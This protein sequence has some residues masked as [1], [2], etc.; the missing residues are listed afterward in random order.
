MIDPCRITG[1]EL[2]S[3]EVAKRKRA[4]GRGGWRP[5]AGR[6]AVLDDPVSVTLDLEGSQIARLREIAERE[7]V[8][9][10]SLVRKAVSGFLA[11]KRK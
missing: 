2:L 7:E 8:S 5:G 6:K 11:R 4:S 9:V 10:A 3:T 1:P